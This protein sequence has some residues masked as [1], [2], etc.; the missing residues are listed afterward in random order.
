MP[1]DGEVVDT[2]EV[3]AEV[4]KPA[5]V[6]KELGPVSAPVEAPRLNCRVLD[7]IA[8]PLLEE[9]S[10]DPKL[11]SEVRGSGPRSVCEV[12]AEVVV[13]E[14]GGEFTRDCVPAVEDDAV[15]AVADPFD[16]SAPLA[17]TLLRKVFMSVPA[18]IAKTMPSPQ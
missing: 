13:L 4:C 14:N 8:E 3:G 12:K 6:G 18:F 9:P 10:R 5:G 17:S 2:V 16:R 11:V 7:K 15:V 1:S